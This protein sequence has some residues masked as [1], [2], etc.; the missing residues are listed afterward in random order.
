MYVHHNT[1]YSKTF[2]GENFCSCAQ[3]T[4]NFRGASGPY[5]YVLY[6]ASDSR[7]KLSR[8]AKKP[9]KFSPSK[10]LPYTVSVSSDVLC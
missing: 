10:V 7:G 1:V 8:L 5:H 4:V 9:R 2:E 3:N 6:T